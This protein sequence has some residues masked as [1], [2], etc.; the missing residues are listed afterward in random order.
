MRIFFKSILILIFFFVIFIIF[1]STIGI[2]TIKFNKPIAKK[3]ENINQDIKIDLKKIKIVLDPFTFKIYA[4]TIGASLKSKTEEIGIEKIKA[5]ISLKSLLENEFSIETLEVSTKPIEI[6]KSFSFLREIQN[7]PKI[8]IAEKVYKKIFSTSDTKGFLILDIKAQIDKKGN[9]NDNLEVDGIVR[10]AQIFVLNKFEIKKTN[11]NFNYKKNNLIFS[12]VNLSLND[13]NFFS[14]KIETNISKQNISFNG[15]IKNENTKL[16]RNQIEKF[17][18]KINNLDILNLKFSSQN[19][20]AL[21]FN[22][23]KYKLDD[24]KFISNFKIEELS[25]RNSLELDNFFPEIKNELKFINQEIKLEYNKEKAL[26]S[27]KGNIIAQDFKDDL[28]FSIDKKKDNIDFDVVYKIKKNPFRIDRLNYSKDISTETS[29]NIK[30][31]KRIKTFIIDSMSLIEKENIMRISKLKINNDFKIRDFN[32]LS[33]N[34][35]DNGDY[36]NSLKIFKQNNLFYL[37]SKNFNANQMIQKLI[38]SND[39]KDLFSKDKF[40]FKIDI[41][42]LVIDSEEKLKSF[43]GDLIISNNS[44]LKAKLSGDFIGDKKLRF[45]VNSN[46]KNKVT[47]LFVDKAKPIISRYK[48]IKGFEEGVLD[49]NSE[50][51]NQTN[52]SISSLK[53][54]NFKLKELPVLTKILTLAS[55]QGIADILSGEGIRFDEFEMNFKDKNNLITIDEIYAIGPAI[56]ILMNGY[57]EKNKLVSLRGTLVPATTINKAIGSIPVL[58]KILVGSKTGEG[59][60]GVSFKIKGPPK[61]LETTVNPIKTLTP[62]FITRTL[63][64]LK[65]NK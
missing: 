22:K 64:N 59:V 35:V 52:E 48:F 30:G 29:I 33:L 18:G 3:I 4:K 57:I 28:T 12:D 61:N 50:K 45:S 65:K 13:I 62:R 2:E 11:F 27:G 16:K 31:K 7:D 34:Y 1:L 43:K 8:Y 42:E 55:L 51:N 36:K 40:K 5:E 32:N 15:N 20:I 25:I 19:L 14:D 10:D 6:T 38:D 39:K 46:K 54:Y 24:Y 26:I 53:I 63:E 47:T 49:F 37:K 17:F 23:K 58:G 41:E 9:F 56:S 21:N 44:I 60:F